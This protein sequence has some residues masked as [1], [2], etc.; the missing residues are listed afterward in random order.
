MTE[1]IEKPLTPAELGEKYRSMCDDP[2]F[3]NVPGKLE[4][5]SWGSTSPLP[6]RLSTLRHPAQRLR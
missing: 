4:I 1:V 3:A 5:D 2:Y 6:E